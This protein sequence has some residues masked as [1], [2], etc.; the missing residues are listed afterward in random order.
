M[1]I[2]EV[3]T[4]KITYVNKNEDL[5]HVLDLMHKN[6]YTKIPVMDNHNLVGIVTDNR[7]ADKLGSIKSKGIPAS[8]LHA[9]S[10]MDNN[11]SPVKPDDDI[12]TILKTVGEPGLTMLPVLENSEI[13]GIVTKADLLSL[14]TSTKN[15]KEIMNENIH[16]VSS[17]D[18]VVHAR[19][20][21]LDN[22]IA[23]IP[24]IDEGKVTGIIA[25]R[26]IAFAFAEIKRAISMGRQHHQIRELLVRDVMETPVITAPG[27]ISVKEAADLMVKHEIGGLPIVD[28]NEKIIGMITRTD[29]IKQLQ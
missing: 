5:W 2:K 3:M 24:V 22:D 18:R 1:K 13:V 26:E 8:R 19:R 15:I 16:V 4:K 6:D 27:T 10:V 12:E 7:I 20:I 23:R 28:T 11:F 25:D 17:D 29:I 14:V 21:L 9:S